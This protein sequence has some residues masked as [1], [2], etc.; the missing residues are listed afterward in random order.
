MERFGLQY[1]E[2]E[3]ADVMLDRLLAAQPPPAATAAYPAQTV[4]SQYAQDYFPYGIAPQ[5]PKGATAQMVPPQYAPDYSALM[6]AP[7]YVPT[8][9]SDLSLVAADRGTAGLGLPRTAPADAS[10]LPAH[11]SEG[12]VRL[13]P[14]QFGPAPPQRREEYS[15]LQ[16]RVH[17][18]EGLLV[19]LRVSGPAQD[20]RR[21][22]A[23]LTSIAPSSWATPSGIP[24]AWRTPTMPPAPAAPNVPSVAYAAERATARATT[25]PWSCTTP[26][27]RPK[28]TPAKAPETPGVTAA[29]APAG[30]AVSTSAT[31]LSDGTARPLARRYTWPRDGLRLE[32]RR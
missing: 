14:E 30:L 5:Y 28:A 29:A 31:S 3:T 24:P 8:Y 13:F 1:D 25:A 23:P 27:V 15:R 2:N 12:P 26:G 18:L 16:Q 20:S 4:P 22:A 17:E 7:P 32:G 10:F 9:A 11:L 6:I 19:S 21:S